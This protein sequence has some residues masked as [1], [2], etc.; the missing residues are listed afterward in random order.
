MTHHNAQ[1]DQQAT[2][3]IRSNKRNKKGFSPHKAAESTQ[4][5]AGYH[6]CGE[7]FDISAAF[8]ERFARTV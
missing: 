8:H 2:N 7:E 6:L 4:N 5:G 1:D 3:A